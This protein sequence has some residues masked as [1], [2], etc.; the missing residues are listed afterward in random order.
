MWVGK[1]PNEYSLNFF[2]N[3]KSTNNSQRILIWNTN[4]QITQSEWT[5]MDKFK[6][7]WSSGIFLPS[8]ANK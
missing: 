1:Y 7:I 6:L 5:F 2:L 4:P 3:N 8:S